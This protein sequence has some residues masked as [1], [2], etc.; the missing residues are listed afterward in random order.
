MAE[1]V[2]IFVIFALSVSVWLIVYPQPFFTRLS[3]QGKLEQLSWQERAASLSQGKEVIGSNWYSGVGVGAYTYYLYRQNSS[4][5]AWFYQPIHNSYLMILA[6]IGLWG[7][8]FLLWI[9]YALVAAIGTVTSAALVGGI[10]L[11]LALDHWW[12]TTTFGWYLIFMVLALVW[13]DRKNKF[14]QKSKQ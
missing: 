10:L 12:W 2:K 1:W 5:P 11:L 9:I 3:G 13:L 14:V 4:Q 8:L 6:E 7:A